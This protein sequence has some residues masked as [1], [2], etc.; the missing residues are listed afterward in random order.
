MAQCGLRD[1]E[2]GSDGEPRENCDGSH[3]G[4]SNDGRCESHVALKKDR[5]WSQGGQMRIAVGF[6]GDQVR[7][8]AGI[9]EGFEIVGR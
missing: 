8:A 4:G 3:G 6:M 1:V 2:I 5:G 9:I 7:I